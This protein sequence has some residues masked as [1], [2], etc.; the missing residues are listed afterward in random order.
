M[1]IRE[2]QYHNEL[3]L[4]LQGV[5]YSA[6]PNEV[7]GEDDAEGETSPDINQIAADEADRSKI[8]MSRKKRKIFE[9]MEV[10]QSLRVSF[11]SRFVA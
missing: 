5:Q 9:A 8:L 10:R 1:A 6:V 3:N 11:V 7:E 2:K 4:E